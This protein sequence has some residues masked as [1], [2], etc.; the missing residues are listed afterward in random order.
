MAGAPGPWNALT[1]V[2]GTTAQQS[3]VPRKDVRWYRV[4]PYAWSWT[5][6]AVTASIRFPAKPC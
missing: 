6:A 2:P 3:G 1:T 5:G 4:R